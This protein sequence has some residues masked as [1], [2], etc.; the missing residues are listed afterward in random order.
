M[1]TFLLEGDQEEQQAF[2]EWNPSA[3]DLEAEWRQMMSTVTL[4]IP[5]LNDDPNNPNP[6]PDLEAEWR[7]MTWTVALDIT[8]EVGWALTLT[9]TL[10][11]TQVAPD[12]AAE[13]EPDF[14]K[15]NFDEKKR[16]VWD[17]RK[18]LEEAEAEPDEEPDPS[19][20]KAPGGAR[21]PPPSRPPTDEELGGRNEVRRRGGAGRGR[22]YEAR[23]ECG[24]DGGSREGSEWD[25]YYNKELRGTRGR[26]RS[27]LV[28]AGAPSPPCLPTLSLAPF[29]SRPPSPIASR[30]RSPSRA[31]SPAGG[32]LMLCALALVVTASAIAD[33]EETITAA[34]LRLVFGARSAPPLEAPVE[35]HE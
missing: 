19:A 20:S 2:N 4:I 27:P 30:P 12:E 11:P 34:A 33:E 23:M 17:V 24:F 5:S 32:C 3:A 6:D 28:Y 13:V 8:G 25:E 22:E 35:A 31:P 29:P 14:A 7:Q 10:T 26:G 1:R 9:L 15:A 16:M 21:P 18:Y